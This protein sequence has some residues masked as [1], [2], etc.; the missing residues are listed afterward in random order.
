M[1]T[2]HRS[3][4]SY[5][6]AIMHGLLGTGAVAGGLM[7]VIEPSGK[8][9]NM[10][11]SLLKNAPFTDFLIPGMILLLLLGVLPIYICISLLYRCKWELGEQLN[12]YPERYWAWSF[13]LYTGHVLLIWIVLQ[14]FWLQNVSLIHLFYFAWGLGIQT[15]TLLPDIQRKYTMR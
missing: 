5:V 15:V 14:M 12:L 4:K 10:P 11:D 6:L 9:L 1:M 7:L 13:S 8:W 3:E 2:T